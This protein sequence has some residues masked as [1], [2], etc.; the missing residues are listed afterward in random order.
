MHYDWILFDADET[1]FSFDD[2]QGLKIMLSDYGVHFTRDDHVAYKK[3]NQP[4]WVKYQN[5]EITAQ[6]LQITR[7]LGWAEKLNVEPDELNG[8]FLN[9]MAD[10][11]K[12]LTDVDIVIPKLVE[13]AKLGIVTNGFTQLQKIR[14]ERTGMTPY[15][16]H[17][18]ISEEIG[19]AKPDPRIFEYALEK[20]GQPDKASVLMVGDNPHSDVLGGMNAGVD[21][22]WLNLKGETLPEG[23]QP[24]FTASSWQALKSYLLD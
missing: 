1:L 17:V 19:V 16:T 2:F 22:C 9:A 12:P 13:R 18:F 23:I 11:C 7:F 10:V 5:G 15:F 14:L 21:T 24:T 4:L 6:E 8:A 3:Q 20:M